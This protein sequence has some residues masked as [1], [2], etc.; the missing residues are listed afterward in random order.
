MLPRNNSISAKSSRRSPS[1]RFKLLRITRRDIYIAL[2]TS[3]VLYSFS[4]FFSPSSPYQDP[5]SSSLAV[6]NRP[7]GYTLGGKVE[8]PK[9]YSD[10][11]AKVKSLVKRGSGGGGGG[12][13]TKISGHSHGW[14]M[15]ERSVGPSVCSVGA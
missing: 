4:S 15:F 1:L 14:T 7:T 11:V 5:S 9:G 13:E 12:G 3:V 10:S 6:L 8:K 2:L